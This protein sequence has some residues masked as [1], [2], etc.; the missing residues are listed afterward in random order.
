MRRTLGE[1]AAHATGADT[2]SQVSEEQPRRVGAQEV[3]ALLGIH[4][5]TVRLI[6]RERLPYTLTPGGAAGRQHRR[7]L[8]DD[9]ARYAREYL[10][11]DLDLAD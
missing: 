8:L 6:P 7:Y 4:R 5:S 9:V 10:D 3:A 1:G 2:L 11:L